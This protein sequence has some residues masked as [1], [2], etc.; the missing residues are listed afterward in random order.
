LNGVCSTCA[1]ETN[2][3]EDL[4]L[5]DLYLI[6]PS[7]VVNYQC[8]IA[9]AEC[10]ISSYCTFFH[11]LTFHRL[12]RKNSLTSHLSLNIN[13]D[14]IEKHKNGK[15][16]VVRLIDFYPFFACQIKES[17]VTFFEN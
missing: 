17:R 5:W 14:P 10:M 2:V 3:S 9:K 4:C 12:C 13:N 15:R 7:V 8:P 6:I 16:D 1:E 11:T